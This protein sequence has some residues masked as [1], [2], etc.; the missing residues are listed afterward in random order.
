MAGDIK[1]KYGTSNQTITC[2]VGASGSGTATQHGRLSAAIDNSSNV[3]QEVFLQGKIKTGT[4][5]SGNKQFVIYALGSADG[6]STYTDGYSAGDADSSVLVSTAR[7]IINVPAPTTA[8]VY[9]FGPIAVSP[10]FGGT[11]P[12]HWMIFVFNDDGV[13]TSTTNGD[14]IFWYQGVYSQYT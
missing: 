1:N 6:G 3:F 12:D 9:T 11:M 7:T 5:P 14:H 8:T 4:S 10:A 2:T 13:T